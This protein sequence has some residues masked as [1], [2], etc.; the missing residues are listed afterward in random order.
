MH[1]KCGFC[2]GNA[3]AV[4]KEM[5]EKQFLRHVDQMRDYGLCILLI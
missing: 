5:V 4:S 1:F 2:D 3:E